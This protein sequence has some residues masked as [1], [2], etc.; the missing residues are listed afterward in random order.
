VTENVRLSAVL[1]GK[2][3]IGVVYVGV[4]ALAGL[5]FGPGAELRSA[6]PDAALDTAFGA[7]APMKRTSTSSTR[8]V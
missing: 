1:S 2:R 4:V 8:A 6:R 3:V 7:D 5:A